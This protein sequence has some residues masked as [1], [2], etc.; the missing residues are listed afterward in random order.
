[1]AY[2]LDVSEAG[3]DHVVLARAVLDGSCRVIT[4]TTRRTGTGSGR[5][6]DVHRHQKG[7]TRR[8]LRGCFRR[9]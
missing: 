7:R 6:L 1:M 2:L 5:L 8:R 9:H 4:R 3:A